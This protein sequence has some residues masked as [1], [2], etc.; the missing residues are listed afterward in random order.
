MRRWA[1]WGG[2]LLAASCSSGSRFDGSFLQLLTSNMGAERTNLGYQT[3]IRVMDAQGRCPLS[4]Q[5]T[6]TVNSNGRT[7]F[8]TCS[9]EVDFPDNPEL[10]IQVEDGGEVARAAIADVAAGADAVLVDPAGGQVAPGGALTVSVPSSLQPLGARYAEFLYLDFDPQYPG[11]SNY[12]PGPGGPSI[13]VAA[14]QHPGH[15]QFWITLD[16]KLSEPPSGRVVSCSGFTGCY[17]QAAAILGPM[18]IDVVP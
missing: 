16:Y 5:A 12:S 9:V 2:A 14:P 13:Q 4:A 6:I 11:E 8:D 18:A 1:L 3:S 15:F 7:P 10:D 17:S